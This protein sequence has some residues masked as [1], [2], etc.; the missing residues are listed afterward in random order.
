VKRAGLPRAAM[1]GAAVLAAWGVLW[2]ARPK[3]SAPVA[4]ATPSPT[5]S[6]IA[7]PAHPGVLAR[8]VGEI[9]LC[10]FEAP[11]RAY[12][13]R[14]YHVFPPNHPLLPDSHERPDRC[15]ASVGEA[16]TAGFSVALPPQGTQEVEGVYLVPVDLVRACVEAANRLGFPVPCPNLLPNP[17]TGVEEPGCGQS[18]LGNPRCVYGDNAFVLEQ[19]GFDVPPGYGPPAGVG[20]VRTELLV[21]AFRGPPPQP[22]QYPEGPRTALG[23][24]DAVLLDQT[25]TIALPE[26]AHDVEFLECPDHFYPPLAGSSIL[27]WR[28]EGITYQV[29]LV[30]YS[31]TNQRIAEVIVANLGLA[32]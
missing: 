15:F 3:D 23:C 1:V 4:P 30:G 27:R 5:P 17:D 11:Y 24:P 18:I 2:L 32:A 19:S 12:V 22:G 29:S 8:A 28:T 25:P 16:E 31:E 6:A 14:G 7:S 9:Y 20:S 26:F 10:P 21:A 13:A